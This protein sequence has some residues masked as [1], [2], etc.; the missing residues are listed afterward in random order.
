MVSWCTKYPAFQV[1]L[2]LLS[3]LTISKS[4]LQFEICLTLQI[5]TYCHWSDPSLLYGFFLGRF[6]TFLNT[7][8]PQRPWPRPMSISAGLVPGRGTS[9]STVWTRSPERSAKP[10]RKNCL[11]AHFPLLEQEGLSWVAFKCLSQP[12]H[13]LCFHLC[14]WMPLRRS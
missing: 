2:V 10:P 14:S 12:L 6:P 7:R 5:R 9:G 1:S 11:R 3:L 13:T 4:V 8:L